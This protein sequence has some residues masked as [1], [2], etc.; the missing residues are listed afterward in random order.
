MTYR[1]TLHIH[2]QGQRAIQVATAE[3]EFL[4]QVMQ[5]YNLTTP[6]GQ[7]FEGPLEADEVGRMLYSAFLV[8]LENGRVYRVAPREMSDRWYV[9]KVKP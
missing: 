8:I 1:A 5:I 3:V 6:D 7:I 2:P 4:N 9:S